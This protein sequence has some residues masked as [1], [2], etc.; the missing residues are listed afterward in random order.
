MGHLQEFRG[1]LNTPIQARIAVKPPGL[2]LTSTARTC[3]NLSDVVLAAEATER[4]R[5]AG[6]FPFGSAA[7]LPNIEI[8][9]PGSVAA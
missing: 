2:R 8:T 9:G 1:N 7:T 4:R 3:S 6:R 5:A